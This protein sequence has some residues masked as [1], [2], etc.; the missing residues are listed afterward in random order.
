MVDVRDKV[1]VLSRAGERS[2][3]AELIQQV[4]ERAVI[5]FV[6]RHHAPGPEES[7]HL[8]RGAT[9]LATT[10][11]TLP[12]LDEGLLRRLPDLRRVVLYATGHEHVDEE[13]LARHGVTLVT[14]P[15]Y[16]TPAVAEH[17]LGL[18]LT[19]ATRAHLANDRSRGW[20]AP[21][22]SLRGIELGGRTLG[23][24]GVGRIGTHLA[25]IAD[26]I[27]MRVIGSDVDPGACRA[28][29]E[30]GVE[31]TSTDELLERSHVVAVSASTDRGHSTIV[32][33]RRMALMR[34]GAL[35]VNIGRPVLVDTEAAVAALRSRRLRGYGVDEVVL[36]P[37][38]HADLVTEGRVLQTG[39]SAW[40]RDE[41]LERGA[42]QFGRAIVDCLR[43]VAEERAA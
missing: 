5:D 36:D 10:N 2:L 38:L 8:L 42:T 14:L 41:V 35:L 31:M 28:A 32:D 13:L 43:E 7:V 29:T 19:L 20:A 1:V 30:V 39:H 9:V 22:V 17:A 33:A 21:D 23:I 18:M 25:R 16:A 11:V 12:V 40:W 27:G 37:T 6:V 15:A 34:E 26:G 3:P 24:I 4:Q